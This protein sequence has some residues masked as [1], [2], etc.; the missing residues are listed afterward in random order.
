MGLVEG[1]PSPPPALK[2]RIDAGF[3]AIKGVKD[4]VKLSDL[5]PEQRDA[6]LP[7]EKIDNPEVGNT[8][9]GDVRK[10][11]DDARS[12]A[13]RKAAPASG[14]IPRAPSLMGEFGEYLIKDRPRAYAAHRKA[15]EARVERIEK[16]AVGGYLPKDDELAGTAALV[17]GIGD[18]G[19]RQR[20]AMAQT[21][22]QA[23]SQLYATP[24]EDIARMAAQKRAEM[25]A[26]GKASPED[27]ASA[28][29]LEKMAG[30]VRQELDKNQLGYAQQRGVIP[31]QAELDPRTLDTDQ[32]LARRDAAQIAAGTFARPVTYFTK[33][34]QSK[35]AEHMARG[36][37]PLLGTLKTF[38]ETFDRDTPKALKEFAEHAPEASVLGW[39]VTA[40]VPQ[41]VLN[42]AAD[43]IALMG[44][45]DF[46]ARIPQATKLETQVPMEY[47][48]A[49]ANA[50]NTYAAMISTARAIYEM[51]AF[52][53]GQDPAVFNTTFWTEALA[54][55][56]GEN[57]DPNTGTVYGGVAA[58]DL[59]GWFS[60]DVGVRV[61]YTLDK[62]YMGIAK[63]QIRM[64]DLLAMVEVPK[65]ENTAGVASPAGRDDVP[66]IMR[67]QV[68]SQR[69]MP[70]WQ[71]G[72]KQELGV[73][74]R[75][76]TEIVPDP[77]AGAPFESAP[78]TT[79]NADDQTLG[80][81]G[82]VPALPGK[83][84]QAGDAQA[85]MQRGVL[86]S[87]TGRPLPISELRRARLVNHPGDHGK[88]FLADP[89]GALD[90]EQ[91]YLLDRF[92]KPYVL[93]LAGWLDRHKSRLPV[94]AVR[95]E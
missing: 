27:I 25:A 49:F 58:Q 43:G 15:V 56:A 39:M 21:A 37:T 55:V 34:E 3:T 33:I 52:R 48:T 7:P 72:S 47:R 20:L 81:A 92:G 2:T 90:A 13:V 6:L 16:S 42:D 67:G 74:G 41:P 60:G 54:A 45:K 10:L 24:P 35:F 46:K 36:G 8:T 78:P 14:I 19:L 4:D 75:A 29:Y 76:G 17:D 23:N 57:K 91:R 18:A 80:A 94:G 87:Q 93:D 9:V 51:R 79:A 89:D 11:L 28:E 70:R 1:D 69:V 40:G 71:S 66:E 77:M 44:N 12:G 38:Y 68:A 85:A 22:A 95:P 73:G 5:K 83:M 65:G 31:V 32:M 26:T 82:L 86:F 61:P 50:P 88:Y 84:L 64:S 62:Q 53:T 59:P 30:H 63:D